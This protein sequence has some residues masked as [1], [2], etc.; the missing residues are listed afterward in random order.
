MPHGF[1]NKLFTEKSQ[2]SDLAIRSKYGDLIDLSPVKGI[3]EKTIAKA[4]ARIDFGLFDK[5]NEYFQYLTIDTD[6]QYLALKISC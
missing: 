1:V 2:I 6:F 3:I 4:I 5:G